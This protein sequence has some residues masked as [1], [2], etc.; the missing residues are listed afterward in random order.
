MWPAL[1]AS[2]SPVWEILFHLGLLSIAALGLVL[3][4]ITFYHRIKAQDKNQVGGEPFTLSHLRCMH[5][6]GQLNDEEFEKAK[7]L[8]I[9]KGLTG[10][11]GGGSL[12]SDEIQPKKTGN[13][14]TQPAD[15]TEGSDNATHEIDGHTEL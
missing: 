2:N 8:V 11:D 13:H 10:V 9:T 1:L 12:P 6:D 14:S 4:G 7:S 3:T 5:R 15:T